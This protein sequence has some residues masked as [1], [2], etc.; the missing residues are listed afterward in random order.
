[1]STI[2]DKALVSSCESLEMAYQQWVELYLQRTRV[3]PNCAFALKS[4]MNL[5]DNIIWGAG[6][7]VDLF[8]QTH[9]VIGH[10]R[11]WFP[12]MNDAW[13]NDWYKVGSDLYGALSKA[14]LEDFTH[15]R[16]SAQDDSR[17]EPP[18]R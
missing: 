7:V 2:E 8:P 17:D 15:V 5:F 6:S 16:D 11:A 9:Y 10:F 14:K 13:L 1:M 12:S 4:K 3:W 18:T